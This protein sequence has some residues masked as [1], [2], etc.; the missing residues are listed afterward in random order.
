MPKPKA[1][2]QGAPE[3]VLTYGDLMSLMLC[4]FVLLAA[5]ANFDTPNEKLEAVIESIRAAFGLP[6]SSGVLKDP[7]H[8]FRVLL[9]QLQELI[10]KQQGRSKAM[11]DI[12]GITGTQLTIRQIRDGAEITLGGPVA[13][14]R[15]SAE[16][17]PESRQIV[18]ELAAT[19][20]GRLN[21]IEVRGHATA[22]PLPPDSPFRDP[23]DLS[24]ARA[25]AVADELVAGGVNPRT[26]RIV[27]AGSNEPALTQAYTQDRLAVNRRVEVIV[28]ESV[29]SEF[30]GFPTTAPVS[31]V[32]PLP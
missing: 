4:F 16:L 32:P 20:S 23:M 11:T 19:L 13:F 22:E 30:E 5:F 21:K 3:W 15:F 31:Q 1:V 18:R 6:G 14:A 29:V 17:R 24:L 7:A 26:L 12:Q 10:R 8:S 25:R 27:G 9:Q 2:V 28:R